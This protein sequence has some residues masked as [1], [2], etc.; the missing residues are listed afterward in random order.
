MKCP[1]CQKNFHPDPKTYQLGAHGRTD[2][3]SYDWRTVLLTCPA[4]AAPTVFVE[5]Q[6]DYGSTKFRGESIMA[7]PRTGTKAPAPP[8]VPEPIARDFNEASTVLPHSAQAS[9]ALSRRC[10]QHVLT[11]RGVSKSDNL[12]TA[13]DDALKSSLPSHL[14]ENLDAV[15]NIGNFAAHPLKSQHSG[16][17]LP[18]Q[19]EEAEWNLEVLELLFDFYYVQPA[20][21]A[22][23]RADLNAKLAEAGKKPMKSPKAAGSDESAT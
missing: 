12:N 16:E 18:V 10:L 9:A 20:R 23:K 7:F 11:D 2:R 21:A 15:R 19:P 13:I 22:A 4:C 3:W 17:I 14:G 5:Y 8:E 1:H 6:Q